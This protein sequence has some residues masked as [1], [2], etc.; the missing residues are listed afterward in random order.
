[1][2]D[3]IEAFERFQRMKRNI[4]FQIRIVNGSAG[5]LRD[6]AN[7]DTDFHRI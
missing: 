6:G 4:L 7:Q 5:V 1:M 3:V 2:S